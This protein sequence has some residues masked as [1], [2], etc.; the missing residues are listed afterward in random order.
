MT[1]S[2][3]VLGVITA[4]LISGSR[5]SDLGS[6]GYWRPLITERMALSILA[7]FRASYTL[8]WVAAEIWLSVSDCT[9]RIVSY[10]KGSDEYGIGRWFGVAVSYP[11]RWLW[12]PE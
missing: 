1:K 11:L 7:G 10:L 2:R 9:R 6:S 4:S 8:P 12:A 3:C 5:F